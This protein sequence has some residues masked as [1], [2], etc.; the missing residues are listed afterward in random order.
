MP[1][2]FTNR[3]P[4]VS[5]NSLPIMWVKESG[6]PGAIL[7][8][9]SSPLPAWLVF[10]AK[11][12]IN[13]ILYPTINHPPHLYITP[14]PRGVLGYRGRGGDLRWGGGWGKVTKP[15]R[16]FFAIFQPAS[17]PISQPVS[18][19]AR[20][21]ATFSFTQP[22]KQSAGY[23]HIHAHPSSFLTVREPSDTR[24]PPW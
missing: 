15:V 9:R 24:P 5:G 1:D 20:E 19:A 7:L 22:A 11:R 17:H 4:M 12:Q 23:S 3:R 6:V 13:F 18:Q 10:S 2:R 14:H 16:L 21:S 8:F